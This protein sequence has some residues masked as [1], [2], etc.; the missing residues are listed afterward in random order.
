[1]E[2]V[3]NLKKHLIIILNKSDL[4]SFIN[5]EQ[6]KKYSPY[7]ITIS[8]KF[9]EGRDRIQKAAEEIFSLNNYDPDSTVF[10]NERQKSCAETAKIHL[11]NALS[12]L[13][14]GATL[15]AVTVTIDCAANA[16]L[17]LTGEKAS[18]AVV[19]EVFSKFCVGK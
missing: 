13:K 4:K 3:C 11:E 8:A 2:Y 15:D 6:L 16:L 7:I 9:N 5:P 12:A 19:N 1:M 17:E 18:E 14:A 10:A